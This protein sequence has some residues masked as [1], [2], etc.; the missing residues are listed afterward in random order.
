MDWWV[1]DGV[2]PEDR[3]SFLSTLRRQTY[4]RREVV[5]HEGDPAETLHMIV[6]GHV[7]AQVSH[8]SGEPLT[9][10]VLGPTDCFG[11]LALV[12]PDRMRRATMTALDTC[13]TLSMTRGQFD[14]L[15]DANPGLNRVLVLLLAARVEKLDYYLLDALYTPADTRVARRLVELCETYRPDSGPVVVPLT[16][17]AIASLAG[18]TRSTTNQA[19]QD[20]V[21]HHVIELGRG[22]IIVIDEPALVR[23]SDPAPTYG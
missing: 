15:R 3:R 2:P 21:R 11:E 17:D 18:T 20:M 6:A 12:G 13:E 5:F 23:L 8:P 10:A 4:R 22:Q 16:Q 7:T 19:L 14:R 9:V 1:L